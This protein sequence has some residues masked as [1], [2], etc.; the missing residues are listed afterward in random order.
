M[1]QPF[2]LL[3][4][5]VAYNASKHIVDVLSR[6]PAELWGRDGLK[7]DI[8][9]IDDAS[10]DGTFEVAKRYTEAF[11]HPLIVRRNE[12]NKGYGGNQKIGYRYAI[13]NKYDAVVLLHGDGQYDPAFIPQLAQPIID[14]QAD[15]VIGSR[16]M[17]RKSAL[18][19]GM[20]LYKF[21]GNIVLT[22]IQN[23][24]LGV[25]L[26]EFHSGYRVYGVA[27]LRAIPFEHNADYFD[28]DTDIL[29]Q[30]FD[31]KQRILEI[32]IPT[33]YGD[34]ICHVNGLKYAWL[35]M[36]STLL[37]RLQKYKMFYR[38]RFDYTLADSPKA[39]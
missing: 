15:V 14:R 16:M 22:S 3:I 5:I 12:V 33:F 30:C 10:S 27:A 8:L 2:R 32:G 36:I 28:F 7:T 4:F 1:D 25:A 34:E 13:E 24:L 39:R 31:T 19:G 26:K 38:K 29:I 9:L 21:I 11:P 35:I 17:D 23:V 20:P 37:S 18:R 6:V